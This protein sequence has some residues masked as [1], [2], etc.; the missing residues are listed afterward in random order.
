LLLDMIDSSSALAALDDD[1]ATWGATNADSTA[2]GLL[3]MVTHLGD[4][5]VVVSA[6]LV[7]GV[8]DFVQ[9]RRIEVFLF[10]GVVIAGEKLIVNGLKEIVDRT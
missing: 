7:G 3:R 8:I 6:L 4:T 2:V 5:P 9:H 10:L 1:V